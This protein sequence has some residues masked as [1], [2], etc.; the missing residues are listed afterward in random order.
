MYLLYLFL[1]TYFLTIMEKLISCILV[2]IYLGYVTLYKLAKY[3]DRF[4]F[5]Y[6][7]HY[8]IVS[9]QSHGT[10]HY[11]NPLTIAHFF[12]LSL[13]YT[14]KI[15]ALFGKLTTLMLDRYLA[16]VSKLIMQ[17]RFTHCTISSAQQ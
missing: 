17:W 13:T 4:N 6:V 10:W 5:L 3:L 11:D 8:Y 16:K 12:F 2:G 9:I 15:F 7:M 1:F 14:F